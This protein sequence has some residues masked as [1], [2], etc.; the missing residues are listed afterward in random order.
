MCTSEYY[1]GI[2]KK[3]GIKTTKRHGASLNAYGL[4]QESGLKRLHITKF[5]PNDSGK[6]KIT[7]TIKRSVVAKE[8]GGWI[9]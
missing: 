2:K 5:Q 1:T 6:G 4:V 7:Q 8:G 3:Q 9:L